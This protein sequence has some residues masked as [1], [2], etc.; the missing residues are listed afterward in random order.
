M[1]W[2]FF[3]SNNKENVNCVMQRNDNKGQLLH[4]N[5]KK[6]RVGSAHVSGANQKPNKPKHPNM[7]SDR[8]LYDADKRGV[9]VS[10]ETRE[11]EREKMALSVAPTNR[12]KRGG[13]E[14][15]KRR[16]EH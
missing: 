6:N 15:S 7:C 4:T 8:Q 14:E 13:G 3:F 16:Q 9:V 12:E 2:F 1:A 5:C 10:G 11:K